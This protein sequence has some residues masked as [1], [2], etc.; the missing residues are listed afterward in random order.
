MRRWQCC[1]SKANR[2]AKR[3]RRPGHRQGGGLR[4][5][6]QDL[7]RARLQQQGQAAGKGQGEGGEARAAEAGA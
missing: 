3:V 2:S 1:A 5:A 6:R 7:G 4:R